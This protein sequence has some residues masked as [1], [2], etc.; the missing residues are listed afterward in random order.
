MIKLELSRKIYSIYNLEKVVEIYKNIAKIE[1]VTE[2][3]KYILFFDNCKYNEQTTVY[4][5]ENYLIGMENT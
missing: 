4:E 5:F 1:I 2:S 3:E